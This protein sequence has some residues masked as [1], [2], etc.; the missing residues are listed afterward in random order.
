MHAPVH[1]QQQKKKKKTFWLKQLHSWHWISSAISL[2]GLLLF[3]FTGITLNHAADVEGSPQTVEKSA[4]LPAPLLKQVA[5][6]NQADS[7]KPLPAPVAAWVEK[8]IGARA[9][10]DAEW[11]ADEI[12]LALPRPGGD[13]WVSIDRQSGA[14]TSEST[15]RGW[16]SYLNDL[17]KGRNTGTAWKWFIDIFAVACFVFAMTGLLLLQ[18]HAAKRPSTWPLVGAGLI[19][20]T[21]LILLFLH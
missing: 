19:I 9:S 17:H 2:I 11:S 3:A 6:D 13:G 5:P 16:I 12:Y 4:T 21:L 7:K 15:S 8:E 10:G 18:L 1:L 20:P 14:V